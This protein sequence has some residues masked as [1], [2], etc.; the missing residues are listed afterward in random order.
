M[1]LFLLKQILLFRP[2]GQNGSLSSILS[3]SHR[4]RFATETR[5]I[6]FKFCTNNLLKRT[7]IM[8]LKHAYVFSSYCFSKVNLTKIQTSIT[9]S[10]NILGEKWIGITQYLEPTWVLIRLFLILTII[11]AIDVLFLFIGKVSTSREQKQV[12]FIL[13]VTV[14]VIN[15]A[16]NESIT[17][18]SFVVL[19]LYFQ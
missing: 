1:F 17:V 11:I 10:L 3:R 13:L 16:I 12:R 7:T 14:D 15:D 5:Q 18:H 8:E 2:M 9:S 4:I 19:S 6:T